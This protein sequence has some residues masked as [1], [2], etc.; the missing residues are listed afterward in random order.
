[1]LCILA[2]AGCGSRSSSDQV[3]IRFWCGFTGADGRQILQIIKQFNAEHPNIR[4]SLQRIEWAQY[5]NKLFVAGLAERAPEV[6][7]VHS[8]SVE[9]FWQAKLLRPVDDL[10]SGTAPLDLGDFSPTIWQSVVREG[11]PYGIPLD[12][13]MIG[14]YYNKK[15]F[16]EAGIVDASGEAKPPRTRDE[17]MDAARRLTRDTDG[18]GE[19]NQYGFVF[20]WFRTNALTAIEQWKGRFFTEDMTRARMDYPPNVEALQFLGDLIYKHKVAPV[21]YS[22]AFLAFLQGRVGMAFEGVYLLNDLRRQKNLEYGVAPMPVLGVEPAAWADSHVM[23]I[24][25]GMDEERTA[26]GWKLVKYLSDHSLEWAESG[27]VPVRTSLLQSDRFKAMSDQQTFAQQIPY[28]RYLPS[29]PFV[30]EFLGALDTAA[31]QVLRNTNTPKAALEWATQEVNRTIER[32]KKREA[33]RT[34][35][36]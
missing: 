5:Y 33:E 31:E 36:P 9:R 27:Q 35:R 6:F 29:I 20:T 4:V 3:H 28:V 14:M 26:A 8:S 25:P 22:D 17:F 15:L 23:C 2:L 21:P 16:R 30:F 1:M 34:Q 32:R 18:N 24:A 11:R 19:P 7:V 13:H 10:A 12:V